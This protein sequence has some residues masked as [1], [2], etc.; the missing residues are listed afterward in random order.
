MF[1]VLAAL[2]VLTAAA[3]APAASAAAFTPCADA[4]SH[5]A[6]AGSQCLVETLPLD[7]A[8]P[9]S[10]TI[11]LFVRRFPAEGRRKGEVWLLAGGPGETG[12]SLYPA[13]ANFRRAYPGYDLVV[14]DHRGTGFSSKICEKEEAPESP[15]GIG[16]AGQEWGPCIGAM[17]ANVLRTQ[18]FNTNNAA[19]DLARLITVHRRPGKVHLYGV[20]YGTQLALRMLAISPVKLDGL[21][22]DGLVPA[23]GV[24][25]WDLSRRTAVVDAVGRATLSPAQQA[26]LARLEADAVAA[27]PAWLGDVPGGDLRRFMGMLLTFPEHRARIPSLIESLGRGDTTLLAR[28]KVDL[29]TAYAGLS[30]FPQSPPSMPL[31]MLINGSEMNSRRDLTRATIDAEA[32]GALFT[33]PIPGHLVGSPAPL[34]DRP[35]EYERLPAA[36]PRTLV[37]HG[38]LDP[39]TPYE[40]ALAHVAALRKAGK[41]EV[42]TVEGGAH[43]LA[44]LDGDCFADSVAR[45]VAGRKAPARCT[46]TPARNR[47]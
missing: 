15:D 31:I 7:H 46:P 14:P 11:D 19:R 22:L 30:A 34:Y 24:D 26:A 33:S 39:N 17:H 42:T 32:E 36:L 1:R 12:A 3:V 9:S 10:G 4:G 45:F 23:F 13:L 21:V 2:A 6:L 35:A 40:G 5:P 41:V 18:A 25:R 47:G 8:T 37:V 27:K 20:S 44:L 16:L 43:Y 29:E 38:T 28:M